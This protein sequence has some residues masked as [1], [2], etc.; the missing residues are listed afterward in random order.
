MI[1]VIKVL[2][3]VYLLLN[4]LFEYLAQFFSDEFSD[5]SC[6]ENHSTYSTF[7]NYVSKIVEFMR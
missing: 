4:E 3:N 6:R 2:I 1:I 7:R 5:G